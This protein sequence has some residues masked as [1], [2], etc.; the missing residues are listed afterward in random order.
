VSFRS[1]LVLFFVLIVVLPMAALVFVLEHVTHD[2]RTGK[3]DAQLA[4][5]VRTS[6]ALFRD[7]LGDSRIAARRV[8][9]D[10]AL[11]AALR[12]GSARRVQVEAKRAARAAGAAYMGATAPSGRVLA[13]VGPRDPIAVQR[14]SVN[15]ADRRLG[16]I[17]VS[18]HTAT[19]YVRAVRR[20]TGGQTVV[21]RGGR[22]LAST[23]DVGPASL[24]SPGS[25]ADLTLAAGT[26]YRARAVDLGDALGGA[27]LVLLGPPGAGTFGVRPAV[28]IGVA[29]FF[30]LAL[31]FTFVLMRSLGGQ[32][33]EVSEKAT[34]DALTGL[35]NRHRFHEMI[36]KEAERSRRFARPVS[37]L[38]IDI[39]DF[40]RINDAHG[41][42]Q[43]DEVLRAFGRLLSEVSREIDQPARYVGEELAVILPETGPDGALEAGERIRRRIEASPVT[44]LDGE[45]ALRVTASVGTASI[46]EVA[47]SAD[48]LVAAA[49]AALYRAKQAG[50]NRTEQTTAKAAGTAA[51]VGT[52]AQT[53]K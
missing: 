40:K 14:V 50:K 31:A 9:A 42:L 33:E 28:A 47:D 45:G 19:A 23:V 53:A 29:A 15:A 32:H 2:S 3:A 11:D 44:R 39:D 8:A 17:L 22:T 48:E 41:H 10:R 12:S 46:P 35:A 30:A 27:E 51:D 7:Y 43:G 34:T 37:L 21:R 16:A 49:D 5:G 1:R 6:L 4:V 13:T 20:L 25:S 18:A 24:P 38:M 26:D 36:A 52:P